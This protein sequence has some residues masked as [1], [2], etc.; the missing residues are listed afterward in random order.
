MIEDHW[1]AYERSLELLARDRDHM[2][3]ELERIQGLTVYP[4][5]ANFVLV[6]V[7]RGWDGRE[8]RNHLITHH[9]VFVRECSNKL[10]MTSDFLPL[11]VRPAAEVER[12]VCGIEQYASRQHA[13]LAP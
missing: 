9:G 3:A 8:L 11:V 10:G 2:I 5:S 12:L 4:S 7:P 6:K 1:P 13:A